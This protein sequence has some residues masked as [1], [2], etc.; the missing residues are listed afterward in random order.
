MLIQAP[1]GHG[2]LRE[3]AA[4]VMHINSQ[5]LR[6]GLRID[7]QPLDGCHGRSFPREG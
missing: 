1:K 7:I 5:R 4:E 6:Q 2:F 3:A